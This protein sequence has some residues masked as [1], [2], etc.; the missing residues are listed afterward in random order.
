M[1][2]RALADWQPAVG[3]PGSGLVLVEDLALLRARS[4]AAKAAMGWTSIRGP[5]WRGGYPAALTP[6]AG[7]PPRGRKYSSAD[8]A[9]AL[10]VEVD[11][12]MSDEAWDAFVDQLT[13]DRPG[14]ERRGYT[15]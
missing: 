4:D 6:K 3:R 7:Q 8:G 14:V 11:P 15:R 2:M 5:G 9:L 1:H 13:E 10:V 12:P